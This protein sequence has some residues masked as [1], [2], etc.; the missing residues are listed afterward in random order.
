MIKLTPKYGIYKQ[1]EYRNEVF[2]KI[3]SRYDK[4]IPIHV[5]SL[6]GPYCL[7]NPNSI[8]NQILKYFIN[9][10]ITIVEQDKKALRILEKSLPI[11][12]RY[13][14]K[15]K[16][17]VQIFDR[18]IRKYLLSKNNYKFDVLIADY[19]SGFNGKRIEEVNFLFKRKLLNTNSQ[20]FLTIAESHRVK[21]KP[22]TKYVQ[23]KSS[24][25]KY[26]TG[27]INIVERIVNKSKVELETPI[28]SWSYKN[29]DLSKHA[30]L[31][32]VLNI[33]VA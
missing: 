15:D 23:S 33:K 22:I 25:K 32:H 9:A 1:F 27:V 7:V 24:D 26:L 6:A 8:E 2:N 12:R 20:V 14:R 29:K 10:T 30:T 5:V 16:G 4:S 17:R 13:G 19:Y 21:T 11:L 31:M 3:K 28:E 18:S